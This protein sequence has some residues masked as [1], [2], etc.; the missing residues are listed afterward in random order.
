MTTK[1]KPEDGKKLFETECASCHR[2]GSI[3]KDFGPDLTTLSSR[4]QK[5]DVLEA[6]LYPS[7]SISDQYQSWIVETR[8][9]DAINGLLVSEDDRKLVL[10]TGDQPRPIEVLKSNLK[11]KRIS[12][13]SIMPENLLDGYGMNEISGLIA[14]LLSHPR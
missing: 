2:F 14:Y 6:I 11:A 7:K 3:G 1:A 10:K 12:R 5:K 13:V 9:G 8:D 4:F